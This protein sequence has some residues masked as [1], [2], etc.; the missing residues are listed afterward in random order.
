[1]TETYYP[2]HASVLIVEIDRMLLA[3]TRADIRAKMARFVFR[4][5]RLDGPEIDRGWVF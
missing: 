2:A 5:R 1:M 3:A 4:D